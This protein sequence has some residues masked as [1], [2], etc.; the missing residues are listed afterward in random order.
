MSEKRIE[1]HKAGFVLYSARKLK[2]SEEKT[3]HLWN[4]NMY[5]SKSHR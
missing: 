4:E 5:I 2:L 1:I 3:S